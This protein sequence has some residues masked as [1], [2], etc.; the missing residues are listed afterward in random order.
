VS[1]EPPLRRLPGKSQSRKNPARRKKKKAGFNFV[2]LLIGAAAIFVI[3]VV[4]G[5]LYSQFMPSDEDA[6]S[7]LAGG[8]AGQGGNSV[9]VDSLPELSPEPVS[10]AEAR[11]FADALAQAAATGNNSV[12]SRLLNYRSIIDRA[13]SD[14]DV[15]QQIKSQFTQGALTGGTQVSA[16]VIQAVKAGG[17][18]QPV[19]YRTEDG[20]R[21]VLFRLT[22]EAGLNYHLFD[23][24][25]VNGETRVGDMFIALTGEN[26]SA[27][28]RRVF[29]PLAQTANRSLLDRLMG[30]EKT[31]VQHWDTIEKLRRGFQS[32][33]YQVGMMNYHKLPPELQQMKFVLLLRIQ[34]AAADPLSNQYASALGA[35][36]SAHPNSV[37][38]NFMAID[39]FVLKQQYA[40]SLAA[41]E[42]LDEFAQND[43]YLN[44]LRGSVTLLNGDPNKAKSLMLPM[45]QDPVFGKE[46]TTAYLDV[47]IALNDHQGT[48]D[49]LLELEAK[50]G[51]QFPR[52]LANS[53]GFEN[54]AR[55]TQHDEFKRR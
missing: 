47:V 21:K 31:I 30:K 18:Y 16:Q 23:L 12:F 50:H 8:T 34:A 43:P 2:P 25:K 55:S 11:Q 42:K 20:R 40:E 49:T 46:A 9:Q 38:A 1:A 45:L 39:Y 44:I 48:L 17:S 35:F 28:L 19:N 33:Q 26:M 5:L 10:D 54:F 52:S 14:V 51:L 37:A 22:G 3:V 13:I 24:I 4:G 27:T 6:G 15:P 41:V 53:E 7:Q 29:I 32:G 36:R